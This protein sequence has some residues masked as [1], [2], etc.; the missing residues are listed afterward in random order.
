M[1]GV[2]HIDVN[3]DQGAAEQA[4]IGAVALG[5]GPA[6]DFGLVGRRADGLPGFHGWTLSGGLRGHMWTKDGDGA[7]GVAMEG[8][9]QVGAGKGRGDD[10]LA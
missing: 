8:Q 3:A 5:L 10:A 9:A 4:G 1:A 6:G 2:E 7:I